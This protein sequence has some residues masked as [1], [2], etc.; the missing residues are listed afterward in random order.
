MLMLR[1]G[2]LH[3]IDANAELRSLGLAKLRV[4]IGGIQRSV[5]LPLNEAVK[6]PIMRSS[7][8]LK[9]NAITRAALIGQLI[10]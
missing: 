10:N 3:E 8:S 2:P 1:D 9:A 6:Q 7:S 5:A 4:S